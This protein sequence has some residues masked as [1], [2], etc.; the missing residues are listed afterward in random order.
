MAARKRSLPARSERSRVSTALPN[1]GEACRRSETVTRRVVTR[2]R[3]SLF[4]RQLTLPPH[5]DL[6]TQRVV[7]GPSWKWRPREVPDWPPSTVRLEGERRSMGPAGFRPTPVSSASSQRARARKQ[8][9]PTPVRAAVER[10]PP[11]PTGF[12][13]ASPRLPRR[14]PFVSLGCRH[15]VA[16]AGRFALQTF[17][18]RAQQP[19]A[20]CRDPRVAP[21]REQPAVERLTGVGRERRS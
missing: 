4:P 16:H 14:H 10:S 13:S 21:E 9:F 5:P 18:C 11:A 8:R 2:G 1:P 7:V 20:Q 3:T 17:P 6:T 19:A 15:R 12:S